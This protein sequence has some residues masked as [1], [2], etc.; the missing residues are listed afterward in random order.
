MVLNGINLLIAGGNEGSESGRQ[1]LLE[2]EGELGAGMVTAS[3]ALPPGLHLLLVLP[4]FLKFF[5][6][7]QK[8]EMKGGLHDAVPGRYLTFKSL[9]FRQ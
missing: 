3:L 8:L 1:V 9:N 6:F 4:G 7:S 5:G 2:E